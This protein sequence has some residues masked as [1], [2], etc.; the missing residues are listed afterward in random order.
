MKNITTVLF[1]AFCIIYFPIRGKTQAN[2]TDSLA[3]LSLHNATNGS[4]WTITWDLSQPVSTWYG[5]TLNASGRVISL[6]LTYNELSGSLPPELGNLTALY[7]DLNLSYNQLTGN[8]PPELGNLTE[9]TAFWLFGNNLTGNIPP[10]LGGLVNLRNLDLSENQLTGNIPP[11]LGNLNKMWFFKL[12]DN[13]LSG[14]IPAE[15]GNLNIV[16]EILLQNNQLT[17]N[18]PPE[19]GNLNDLEYL[20]L[21]DNQLSGSF[22]PN[23]LNLCYQLSDYSIS[24]GNSFDM[25]WDVFCDAAPLPCTAAQVTDSLA[26]VALYNTANGANWL[27]TWNLTECVNSWYGVTLD[28]N[29]F[30]TELDLESNQLNGSIPPDIGNLTNLRHLDLNRN[31]LSG[32]MPTELFNLFNLTYLSL[33]T[34]QLTGSIS[35][36]IG[37][38]SSLQFMYL[39]DNQLTGSIPSEIGSLFDLRDLS[40]RLNQLSGNIPP[41]LGNLNQLFALSLYANKLSGNIPPELG[42]LTNLN[43][44]WLFENYLSGSIPASLGNLSNLRQLR[45]NNNQLSG[46]IPPELGNLSQIRFLKLQE[47]QLTG[48]I[49][50]ELLNLPLLQELAIHNNQLTGSIPDFSTLSDI[51]RLHIQKNKFTFDSIQVNFNSNNTITDFDYSPQYHGTPQS[52]IQTFGDALSFTL[53]EPL[54]GNNNQ[55]VTYQWK[56]NA[57]TIVGS[58]DTTYMINDLQLPDIGTYTLHATDPARVA[59]LEVVS[60]PIYVIVPGYD[61]YGQSVAYNQIMVEFGDEDDRQAYENE[62]LFAN[63][64]F[65]QDSCSCNRGLYL[66]QFP[67]D[68]LALQTLLNINTKLENQ[69]TKGD[70]D[71]GPNNIF[72]LGTSNNS[73]AAWSWTSDYAEQY[74]D[75]VSVF[76]LDSGLDESSWDASPYLIPDA[77]KDSCYNLTA[78][79]YDYTDSLTTFTTNY[80]DSLGHGTYGFRSIVEG[81]DDYMTVKSVPLKVFDQN[82]EGT[83]FKFVCALYHAIDQDADVI[84]ISAGYRGQ[85]SEILAEAIEFAHQKGIFIVTATGNDAQNIDSIP[86]FPA[87]FSGATYE[88]F[89]ESGNVQNIPYDNVISVASINAQ[90]SLSPFSNYGI[91]NATIAAY[92]ENMIGYGLSGVE[93]VSSGTSISTFYVTRELVA[94]IAKNKNRSLQQLWA[95]FEAN[96]LT[97]NPATNGLTTTGKRLDIQIINA[98]LPGGITFTTQQQIDDF[99][100]NYSNCKEVLGNLVIE[101]DFNLPDI[102]SLEGL[103][104]LTHISGD[105]LIVDNSGLSSLSGLDSLTSIDGILMINANNSLTSITGLGNIDHTTITDL[106]IISNETLSI[107]GL[108]NICYYL[109]TQK[110]RD[111][112]ANANGCSTE[113][114]ILDICTVSTSQAESS[115][116]ATVIPNPNKGIFQIFGITTGDYSIYNTTGQLV[117]QGQITNDLTIDMTHAPQGIYFI[118]IRDGERVDTLRFISQ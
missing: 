11:E 65:V 76:M 45:L 51:G 16:I 83:L 56:K 58:T 14:N 24:E 7:L 111:I 88:Q 6:N 27:K 61:L 90:N 41:E 13:Q 52:F 91:D 103:H 62:Y 116:Q 40:L 39:F 98:C 23:L 77:P 10:E 59:G 38:L 66:W 110:P 73:G 30:V 19:L 50:V 37:N 113:A 57:F 81:L 34:N 12:D 78:A 36:E 117:Q 93:L 28:A 80:A 102:V 112:S 15:L 8:I 22:D 21:N 68:T 104:Q 42:N 84:N 35:P 48:S 72:N 17:G 86:Q 99:A 118:E 49:P 92:G 18:I 64:G 94:E 106:Q 44:L 97:D 95:D 26:L 63:A 43:D 32:D 70:V 5:V 46:S 25:T 71:G 115:T 105:L 85:S 107:C 54:P 101:Q 47:N 79:G 60:E 89:D 9:L 108:D 3:L 87:Y 4:N 29:G 20:Y 82:G 75:S 100:S 109:N 67:S 114:E 74:P 69:D 96:R 31:E 1:V 55:N 2:T 33:Y 53:S